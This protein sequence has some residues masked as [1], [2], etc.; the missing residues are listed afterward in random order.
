MKNAHD[1]PFFLFVHY[2][3]THSPYL[4]PEPYLRRF[5]PGGRNPYDP[6]CHD[7]DRAYNHLAYPF[8]KRHHYDLMG[9]VSDPEYLNA[10]Y[11]GEV[12]YLDDQLEQLDAA[13][14]ALGLRDDT[15]WI[16]LADHGESFTEHDIFWDHCGLY[17]P[18]VRVPLVMR[19][20]ARIAPGQVPLGPTDRSG[21]HHLRGPWRG[22]AGPPRWPFAVDDPGP[23]PNL[24]A[25]P[26]LPQRMPRH[27]RRRVQVH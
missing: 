20:P 6:E 17:E 9:E 14:K 16:L 19:W 10:R 27:S 7:M 15:W 23:T 13:L 12:R 3:D 18:T 8:F 4:P 26:R 21:S 11:D 5:Y 2:W 25:R 1:Q 22:L 24:A